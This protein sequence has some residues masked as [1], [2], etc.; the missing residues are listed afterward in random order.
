[1]CFSLAADAVLLIHLAFI[2]FVVLGAAIAFLWRWTAVVHL[3]AAAWGI[4]VELT[5][6]ICPLTYLENHFRH[7]AGQ[8]G[9]PE[10]FIEHYL[11]NIIYPSSLTQEIQFILAGIVFIIN[12]TIYTWLVL[13]WHSARRREG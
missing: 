8:A 3:P 6:R 11:L 9:Y 1:M 4:Y 12:G 10:S 2:V 13:G 5:G 7:E